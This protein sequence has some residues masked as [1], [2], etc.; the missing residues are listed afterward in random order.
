MCLI[1]YFIGVFD[2]EK[3]LE[4]LCSK[5]PRLKSIGNLEIRNEAVFTLLM[6]INFLINYD[7]GSMYLGARGVSMS[8][9]LI[10]SFIGMLPEM[11]LSLAVGTGIGSGN[12]RLSAISA[13]IAV[14]LTAVSCLAFRSSAVNGKSDDN[15]KGDSKGDDKGNG[16]GKGNDNN[17][18]MGNGKGDSKGNGNGDGKGNDNGTGTGNG[19]GNDNGTGT[20]NDETA[21]QS[22]E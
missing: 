13:A 19:K 1:P 4:R 12:Y 15:G 17:K 10:G 20:G 7:I 8:P 18:G 14:I 6:R 3:E 9:Y 21:K 5:Y 22:W 2:G 11:L 16:N